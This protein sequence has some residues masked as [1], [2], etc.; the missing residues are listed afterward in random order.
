MVD[1]KSVAELYGIQ[2]LEESTLGQGIV[3][4]EVAFFG[5]AREQIT[6]GTEFNDNIGT[7]GRI[8]NAHQGNHVGMLAGQV[9]QFDLPL[10]VLQLTGI[11]SGLVE[12]FDGIHHIGVDIHGSVDD[13]VSADAQDAGEF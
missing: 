11:K 6:F 5:D 1:S 12:G 8:H 4:D 10:L 9:M 7:I 13:T 2:N 3:A